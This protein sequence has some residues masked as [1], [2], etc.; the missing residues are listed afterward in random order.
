[1]SSSNQPKG[2]GQPSF[3]VWAAPWVTVVDLA[4]TSR[5][6]GLRELVLTAHQLRRITGESPTVTAALH[7]LV[8]A[9]LHRVYGPPTRHD[10][11][12]LWQAGEFPLP[13]L[14]D[15]GTR[16]AE[17]FDLFDSDRPFL[18][19]AALS[20]L[21]PPRVPSAAKLVPYRSVG[22]NVTLFD[23]TTSKDSVELSAAEAARWLVA[24]HSYDPGGMKTPFIKDKS[25]ERAH[26]N[27][28][29][30]VL[31]EGTTLFET[32]LL[33]LLTYDRVEMP[34]GS[35]PEDAPVWESPTSP[36][37]TPEAGRA[38]RGWTD[39]LTWPSRRVWL[40]P[41]HRDGTAVVTQAVI[42]PGVRLKVNLPV[43]EKLACFRIPRDAKGKLNRSAGML[44]VRLSQRRGVW[45]HSIELLVVDTREEGRSRQRPAALDQVD[46]LT[47]A[48]ILPEDTVY[49]L[50]VFGQRLDSKASVVEAWS[51]ESVPAPVALLRARDDRLGA[52][53]GSA[54]AL[55][56]NAGS[57]LRALQSRFR[58]GMRAEAETDLDAGYW[59]ALTRPFGEL[60]TDLGNARVAGTAE[61]VPLHEWGIVVIRL[62][63]D[64]A[65]RWTRGSLIEGRALLELGKH[66]GDLDKR[67]AGHRTDYLSEITRYT[68]PTEETNA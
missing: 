27:N 39:L 54:I 6:V 28:F 55:A 23:H 2:P 56:D 11:A 61:A 19:S 21:P 65:D 51:E 5:T 3:S 24:L 57:A 14:D 44:P 43:E 33:N 10:W 62:A 1:M 9:L 60:L 32:L 16:F 8:L 68:S 48:G 7:R 53:L 15:Y 49:T 4:G 50:R 58:A 22:N 59:P 29:G 45:R 63:R 13:P 40:R 26:C 35:S 67:L 42:T 18:Q 66:R 20:T 38:P 12:E 52:L 41:A 47:E 37:G 31:V 25:S 64:A 46:E 36:P 17:A 34:V 30:M